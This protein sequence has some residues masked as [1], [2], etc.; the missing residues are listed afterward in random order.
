MHYILSLLSILLPFSVAFAVA[1]ATFWLAFAR[2]SASGTPTVLASSEA[3]F[4]PISVLQT[5]PSA[6][7]APSPHPLCALPASVSSPLC[8]IRLCVSV[9]LC[10]ASTNF[11][12]LRFLRPLSPPSPCPL[13]APSAGVSSPLC[14]CPLCALLASASSPL[15]P[16]KL[17]ALCVRPKK[18]PCLRPFHLPPTTL[19][20]PIIP[21]SNSSF[22]IPHS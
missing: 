4:C 7:S 6:P 3:F 13:R 9:P 8:P 1:I 22:L 2:L 19:T 18:Y 15:C 20:T 14:L 12:S 17:C 16:E 5:F 10:E 11:R 21:H